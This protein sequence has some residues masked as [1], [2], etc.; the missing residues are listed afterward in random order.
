MFNI[1]L[2]RIHLTNIGTKNLCQYKC[3]TYPKDQQIIIVLKHGHADLCSR[4]ERLGSPQLA[5]VNPDHNDVTNCTMLL[6]SPMPQAS[7]G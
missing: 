2:P 7:Q 4:L 5:L 6:H 1:E 3:I